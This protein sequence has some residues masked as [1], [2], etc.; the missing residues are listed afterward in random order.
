MYSVIY[1]LRGH[2]L[3]GFQPCESFFM[4]LGML[5]F[6]IAK[7]LLMVKLFA[8]FLS[9]CESVVA[10]LRGFLDVLRMNRSKQKTRS[11]KYIT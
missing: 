1:A 5:E 11:T 2:A 3:D 10:F 6:N 4:P 8:I 9:H 7:A